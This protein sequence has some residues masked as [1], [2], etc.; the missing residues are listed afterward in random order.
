MHEPLDPPVTDGEHYFTIDELRVEQG[1]PETDEAGDEVV[2]R[3][4]RLAEETI[5]HGTGRAFIPR[6]RTELVYGQPF[7]L[8]P[9]SKPAVREIISVTVNGQPWNADQLAMGFPLGRR[10]LYGLAMGTE[11]VVVYSHGMDFPPRRIRRAAMIATRI[12]VQRGPVDDRA[13]Q[14]PTDTGGAVNLATPGMLGSIVG[15]PEVDA[16]IKS[17]RY[18]PR[19]A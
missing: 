8:T 6:L 9:L 7:G 12:W 4:R 3:A 13:T 17:Y 1:V 2:E 15:I 11:A 5:E 14:L 19:L 10:N 16:A 18:A